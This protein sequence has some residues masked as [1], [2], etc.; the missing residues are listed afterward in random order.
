MRLMALI[1]VPARVDVNGA[2]QL[3]HSR[4]LPEGSLMRDRRSRIAPGL[5]EGYRPALDRIAQISLFG[6]LILEM[7]ARACDPRRAFFCPELPTGGADPVR[8]KPTVDLIRLMARARATGTR[9]ICSDGSV[10]RV[11]RWLPRE[12]HQE[13]ATMRAAGLAV[14]PPRIRRR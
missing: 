4:C 8:M 2:H 13:A 12:T 1:V 9:R 6:K 7:C 5:A 14:R 10:G 11:E 3:G